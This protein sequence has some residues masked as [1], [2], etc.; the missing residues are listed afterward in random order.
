[1]E[2]GFLLGGVFLLDQP[3]LAQV[4]L[5]LDNARLELHFALAV[6]G[7]KH[8]ALGFQVQD[9]HLVAHLHG[10]GGLIHPLGLLG[11]ALG[12]AVD[13]LLQ[14]LAQGGRLHVGGGGGVF[15]HA[16][17]LAEHLLGLPAGVFQDAPGLVLGLAQ[18]LLPLG[19]GLPAEALGLVPQAGGFRRGLLGQLPLLFGDLPV[20]LRVGDHVLKALVLLAEELARLLDEPL[21]KAQLAADLK[22]VALARHADGQPVG[23]PQGLHVELHAGILHPGGGKGEGL[24]F[25]V[26]GGGQGTHLFLQQG[27]ENGLGQG[28][29]LGG[30]SARPQLVKERQVVG[31]YLVEDT[32]DVGHVAREG[33]QA[34]LDGLLV[35]DVCKHLLEHRQLRA[36]VRGDLQARLGHEGKQAHGFQGHRL[37][38]GVGAGDNQRGELPAHPQIGGHHHRPVNEGMPPTDDVDKAL[39]VQLGGNGVHLPA[40]QPL[41]KGEVQLGQQLH[42]LLE[43]LGIGGHLG[44]EGRQ[45][46]LDLLLFLG[47]PLLELVAHLHHHH[48]L[49]KHR[50]AA[51]GLV[52]HQAGNTG[53]VLR[54]HR[55]HIAVVAHGDNGVL[56][57][58]LVGGGAD[59]GVEAL[60]HP[61]GGA[62]QVA[63]DIGQLHGGPVGDL[64]LGDNGGCDVVLQ[65]AEGAQQPGLF[66]QAG[67]ILPVGDQ[68]GPGRAA[69]P[70]ESGDFQQR[71]G[72]QGRA[73][74]A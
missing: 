37:A 20:V 71:L 46:A 4:G 57:I 45:D 32:H 34:L 25:A 6:G 74:V 58:L 18:A 73:L 12:E 22:G 26:M 49:H 56:Q 60:L 13:A 51:G 2:G 43:L 10:L 63:A 54:L 50:G 48:G 59:H 19:L 69:G 21:R 14:A 24:Q 70:H 61:F 38:A 72:G 65:V 8:G 53:A 17:E 52:M 41:G 66:L 47:L 31:G 55:Q 1:M 67:G 33:G 23:G 16:L 5:E 44:G 64:V 29:A 9:L 28:R 62:A 39:P 11:Q 30:I 42:I 27:G 36:Q 7:G 35:P 40:E 3:Q 15:L 68:G